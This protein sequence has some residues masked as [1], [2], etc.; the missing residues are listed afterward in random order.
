MN[1]TA[2]AVAKKALKEEVD[3]INHELDRHADRE[4]LLLA[5][6]NRLNQQLDALRNNQTALVKQRTELVSA[7]IGIDCDFQ[8]VES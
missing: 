1:D 5:D 4:E 8:A 7:L 2:K 3:R 6:I